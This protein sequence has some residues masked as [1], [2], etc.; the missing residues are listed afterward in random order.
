MRVR[1]LYFAAIKELL[2]SAEELL[3]VSVDVADVALVERRL[4]EVHP[5]LDG[6]LA[7]VRFAVNEDFAERDAPVRSGDVVAVIPPVSGG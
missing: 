5:E 6:R 2:G 3:D 1:I 4:I 7:T